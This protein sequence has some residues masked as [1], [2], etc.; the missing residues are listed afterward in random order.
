MTITSSI[1]YFRFEKIYIYIFFLKKR[2]IFVVFFV[3]VHRIKKIELSINHLQK[4]KNEIHFQIKNL[5]SRMTK[6][7]NKNIVMFKIEFVQIKKRIKWLKTMISIFQKL[8]VQFND[9]IEL[10]DEMFDIHVKI[11]NVINND[12]KSLWFSFHWRVFR[13]N[14]FL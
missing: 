8:I 4:T 13:K 9:R 5:I 6:L 1:Y 3:F 7:K 2:S 12:V 14:E 10:F 11:I